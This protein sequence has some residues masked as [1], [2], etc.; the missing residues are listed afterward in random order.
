M[1]SRFDIKTSN[2]VRYQIE[3]NVFTRASNMLIKS[4]N[5]KSIERRDG[6][7]KDVRCGE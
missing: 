3:R 2:G 1:F 5:E 7:E 4:N 6:I